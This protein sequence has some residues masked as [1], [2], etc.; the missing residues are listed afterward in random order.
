MKKLLIVAVVFGA[1]FASCQGTK[2]TKSFSEID[3]LSYAIGIDMVNQFQIR[4]IADSVLEGD[5]FASA[6]RD[7]FDDKPQMTAE[8]ASAFIQE[9]FSV[10]LPAKAQAEN[11][12]WFEEVKADIPGVQTT[13]SGL[14]YV[15]TN[16]G[17][18]SVKA[19]SDADRVTVNYRGTLRDGTEFDRN[20]SISFPLNG[21]IRGWTEGMKLV[22]KGGEI[23]LWIP[24]DLGYGAQGGGSIPPN[25]PLKFEIKLLDVAPAAAAE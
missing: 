1:A 10:R 11:E 16:P 3:S 17:D 5:I 2:S 23:T 14:M 6:I 18:E 12:A 22:G 9:Y 21:V 20:D 24:S 15:I 7:A 8:D 19:V 13:E 4:A 25:S